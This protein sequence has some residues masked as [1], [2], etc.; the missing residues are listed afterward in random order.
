MEGDKFRVRQGSARKERSQICENV[1]AEQ[2]DRGRAGPRP[3]GRLKRSVAMVGMMG[4]GK[5]AVGRA[6]AAR[7]EVPFLDSDSEIEAA[8]ACS[9]SEIFA[10]DGEAF[11]RDREAE[12]IARLLRGE[13]A[14]LSTGG[15]AFLAERNRRAIA[16]SGVSLWLDADLDLLWERVRH[17][18]TRPL[19]RTADPKATLS[20]IYHE[21]V[22]LYRQADLRV[23]AEPHYSI[24]DMTD[25]VVRVLATRADVLEADS[26]D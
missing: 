2:G 25:A 21:R 15:G 8:A 23:Q 5:T 14:I 7:L 19:L 3:G 13:P 20:R 9:I 17:R 10:R 24:E 18:D 4:S 11:F 26:D 16:E 1:M 22:P 6:L 12:V